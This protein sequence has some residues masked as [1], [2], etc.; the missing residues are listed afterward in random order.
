MKVKDRNK[1][2]MESRNKVYFNVSGE[3]RL[4]GVSPS[5]GKALGGEDTQM[6]LKPMKP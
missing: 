5:S 2:M 6:G 4:T 3:S 1:T